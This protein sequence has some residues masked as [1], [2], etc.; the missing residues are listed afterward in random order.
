MGKLRFCDNFMKLLSSYFS[1]RKQRIR[2]NNYMSDLQLIPDGVP[3]GS[4]LDPSLFLCYI[5]DLK[6]VKFN[7]M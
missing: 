1:N 3:Q 6:Y 7:S 4:I 2:L 5:N